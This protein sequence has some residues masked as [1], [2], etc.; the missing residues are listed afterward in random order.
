MRFALERGCQH[1]R[2]KAQGFRLIPGCPQRHP[3]IAHHDILD[4]FEDWITGLG[5]FRNQ[6]GSSVLEVLPHR[7]WQ[8]GS[9]SIPFHNGDTFGEKTFIG[10]RG[11]GSDDV[12]AV[13]Y[14]IRED[15]GNQGCRISRPGQPAAFAPGKML[16]D[17]VDLTNFSPAFQKELCGQLFLGEVKGWCGGGQQSAGAP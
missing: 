7:A 16:A 11:A 13:S 14:H 17:A 2:P 5:G 1:Q 3:V 15:K 12:E 6:A 8:T 10:H 4:L 9:K